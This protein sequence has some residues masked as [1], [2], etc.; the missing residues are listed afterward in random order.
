MIQEIILMPYI[1]NED[2]N[3]AFEVAREERYMSKAH[4]TE[5][6]WPG[7]FICADRCR[8]RRNT[9]IECGANRIVVS[10]VGDYRDRDGKVDTIGYDRYYETA[11]FKACKDG[12]YWDANTSERVCFESAWSIKT[13]NALSDMRANDMHD[14]AC[15]EIASKMERGEL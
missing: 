11:A 14:A 12:E 4:M 9:L 1:D 3:Y 2:D 5:R 13:F 15:R 7:H 10:T 6:G 8:F